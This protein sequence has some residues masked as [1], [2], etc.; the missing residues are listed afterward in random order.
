MNGNN[1]NFIVLQLTKLYPKILMPYNTSIIGITE[2]PITKEH[3][4]VFY[5]DL[6][7]FFNRLLQTISFSNDYTLGLL[8]FN[9]IHEITNIGSG[10]YGTVSKALW[11]APFKDTEVALKRLTN[12]NPNQRLELLISEVCDILIFFSYSIAICIA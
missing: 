3:Y 4:I 12:E 6:Q 10:G 2:K 1:I 11:K 7:S 8:D 9:D 5:Y